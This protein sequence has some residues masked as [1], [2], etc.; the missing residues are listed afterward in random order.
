MFSGRYLH[1]VDAKGRVAIPREFRDALGGDNQSR[2]IVTLS[3]DED[4][5]YLDIYPADKWEGIITDVLQNAFDDLDP[6]DASDAREAFLHHYVH[7][8]LA[9]QL[10]GQ[11][12]ILVPAE[13]RAAA[14]LSTTALDMA[15]G[16]S[17]RS[18]CI[19]FTHSGTSVGS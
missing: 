12:R 8:A 7:P 13:H 15:G 2:V 3:P 17:S 6:I 16:V 18:A 9:Q 11:G 1:T 14:G 5:S 19:F 10:D 4:K